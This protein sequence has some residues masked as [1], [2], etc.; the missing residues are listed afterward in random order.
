MH[1]TVV[2]GLIS[3]SKTKTKSCIESR[4]LIDKRV[5]TLHYI[6]ALATCVHMTGEYL[7]NKPLIWENWWYG[8]IISEEHLM[9]VFRVWFNTIA[10]EDFITSVGL[11]AHS[12]ELT[13]ASLKTHTN[14]Q[15]QIHILNHYISQLTFTLTR[16]IFKICA[17][18]HMLVSLCTRPLTHTPTPDF[19]NSV[20]TKLTQAFLLLHA[21][22]S[23]MESSF[24]QMTFQ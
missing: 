12:E 24:I 20:F 6:S 9:S 7:Y 10:M 21:Q 1:I 23:S 18:C 22:T 17:W 19:P 3:D 5:K 15:T 11:Q 16:S 13:R 14:K 8:V 2:T 4:V